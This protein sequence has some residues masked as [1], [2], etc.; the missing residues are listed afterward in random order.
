MSCHYT[1]KFA[2]DSLGDFDDTITVQTQS[3]IPLVIA[4]EGRRPSPVLT[5]ELMLQLGHFKANES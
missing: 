5:R 1:V 4:I 3:S 2:P